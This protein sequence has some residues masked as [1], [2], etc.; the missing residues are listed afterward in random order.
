MNYKLRKR[1]LL[2]HGFG[3]LLIGSGPF[4]E[5]ILEQIRAGRW[6]ELDTEGDELFIISWKP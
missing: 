6:A 1:N 4:N 5:N 3:R 2:R